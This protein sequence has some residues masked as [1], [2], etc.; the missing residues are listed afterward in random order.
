MWPPASLYHHAIYPNGKLLK[1]QV[2]GWLGLYAKHPS[3]INFVR[4]K[5]TYDDFWEGFN[6]ILS[7]PRVKV[8]AVLQGGW[9]DT[10]IQGT[11]DAFV[12]RQELGGPGAKGRQ[13]L[14]IGPWT[15][16]WP[17]VTK[18]GGYDLPQN[19]YQPPFDMTPLRWFDFYLKGI[20]N[21]AA[22]VPAVTYYVMGPFDGSPSSGN[23]WKTSD[24]WP[25]PHKDVD[26]Y[27]TA[28]KKLVEKTPEAKTTVLKYTH[29][30]ANPV[31]TLGGRN[32]FLESGPVDQRPIEQRSDVLVFTTEPL[33]EDLEVTGQVFTR[34]F[35]SSEADDTDVTVRLTDVYPDG[36]SVIIADGLSRSKE[37]NIHNPDAPHRKIDEVVVDLW[38]TSIVFAKG[39]RIRMI[40]SGSNFPRFDINENALNA[41]GKSTTHTHH[42]NLGSKYPS[43]LILPV[44]AK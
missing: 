15:H 7:A 11:I 6:T 35:F 1:S 31:P 5:S 24:V 39:H 25:V 10:F 43:R 9:Y 8:P 14:L 28:D 44:V 22:D 3:V 33:K 23:I 26:F 30:S 18:L 12:S 37:R 42:L 27:L 20:P 41:E 2:E 19:A 32:L 40:I 21:K 36:Q 38:S 16:R 34:L 4:G 29:D 13:K 17:A